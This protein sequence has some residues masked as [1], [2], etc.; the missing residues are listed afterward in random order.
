MTSHSLQSANSAA[1]Q[2][3]AQGSLVSLATVIMPCEAVAAS[4]A[5]IATPTVTLFA[6][7]SA[8]LP[9]PQPIPVERDKRC[10]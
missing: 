3:A 2:P 6:A 7:S 4:R 1:V 5:S 9:V 8:P 10:G